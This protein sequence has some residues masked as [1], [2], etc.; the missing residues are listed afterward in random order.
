MANEI[1]KLFVSLGLNDKEFTQ[2][3]GMTKKQVQGLGKSMMVAGGAMVAGTM[4]AVKSWAEA[5]DE[6]QKMSLRT[7]WAAES[8][9]E[10]SHVAK[11]SGTDLSAFEKG[12]RRMSQA[13]VDASDGLATYTREFER[14]GLDA[15]ELKEMK[16]EEA[17]WVITEALGDMTNEI[18][19][20]SIAQRIFGRTG[21]QLLPMLSQGADGIRELRQEAHELGIV[22]DQD[23]ADAAANMVDAMTRLKGGFQGILNEVAEGV[24]PALESLINVVTDAAKAINKFA[25]EHPELSH[26]LALTALS[27][28]GILTTMGGM[29]Y[30]LPSLITKLGSM[31]GIMGKMAGLKMGGLIAGGTMIMTGVSMLQEQNRVFGQMSDS[32]EKMKKAE[33]EYLETGAAEQKEAYMLAAESYA[34][35]LDTY[36]E[37]SGHRKEDKEF[38]REQADNIREFVKEK[39]DEIQAYE[40]SR[41]ARE[42]ELEAL[43]LQTEKIDEMIA[44]AKYMRSEAYEMGVT[45][46]DITGIMVGANRELELYGLNWEEI[47]TDANKMAK[48]LGLNIENVA[49]ATGKLNVEFAGINKKIQEMNAMVAG[50]GGWTDLARVLSYYPQEVINQY[51]AAFGEEWQRAIT[52]YG[53]GTGEVIT[54]EDYFNIRVD[55]ELDG[56]K[57]GEYIDQNQGE[58]TRQR[59]E[60]GGS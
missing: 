56:E 40:D 57:V 34:D 6:V 50:G 13:I 4:L 52:R 29:L 17:F 15:Q 54:V 19:Q 23:A 1:A 59:Q 39:R 36:M 37:I 55:V 7:K 16:P 46:E 25:D 8:L 48:A 60:T 30:I 24:A 3:M 26:A 27:L 31:A 53:T 49:L 38:Y 33:K 22:F 42:E 21:T 18:E 32:Y 35:M 9:S 43:R 45:I 2:K 41:M 28:G 11:I 44:Q 12:T 47:G 5:G 51:K 58:K 14:L 10:L 20:A